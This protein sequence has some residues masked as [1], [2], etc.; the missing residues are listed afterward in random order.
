MLEGIFEKFDLTFFI[1]GSP[2]FLRRSAYC[3][4][5]DMIVCTG[6]LGS[7]VIW[8]RERD[9]HGKSSDYLPLLIT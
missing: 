8:Q 6:E 9:V 5:L 2:T 4:S 3:S 7:G 1:D